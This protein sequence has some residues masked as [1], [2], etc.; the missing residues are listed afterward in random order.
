LVNSVSVGPPLQGT[1]SWNSSKPNRDEESKESFN[2]VLAQSENPK[3]DKPFMAERQSRSTREA[4]KEN[5]G[6]RE[7]K[8]SPRSS[9]SSERKVSRQDVSKS[10]SEESS[11]FKAEGHRKIHGL[12]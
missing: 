10:S 1:P 3:G 4:E 8:E 12:F 5:Q 9:E 6:V 11:D 7:G 2:Q